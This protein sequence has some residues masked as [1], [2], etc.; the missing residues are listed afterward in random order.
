M[1]AIVFDTLQFHIE[2]L[3]NEIKQSELRLETKVAEAKA[4]LVRWVVAVGILQ[5][6]LIAALMSKIVH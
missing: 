1:G 4:E 5:T 2:L 3:K 6:A